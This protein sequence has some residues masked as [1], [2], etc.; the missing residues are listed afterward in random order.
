MGDSTYILYKRW[1]LVFHFLY[2]SGLYKELLEFIEIDFG[3]C[4][5]RGGS[6]LNNTISMR[7]PLIALLYV[8]P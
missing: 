7:L 1:Q 8:V 3:T 6:L 4:G 2:P 5:Q